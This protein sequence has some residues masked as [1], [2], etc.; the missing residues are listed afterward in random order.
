VTK[1]TFFVAKKSI[2]IQGKLLDL[3]NP[4]VMGIL[5]VTPDSFFEQSR[6]AHEESL[7]QKA[8]SMLE[9]GA[10]ILDIGG[11]ST[12]PGAAD[13][14]PEEELARV[15]PAIQLL[16]KN[17]PEV[18]ISIDTFRAEVA[19]Q[20]I[21]A[22]ANIIN[23]VSGGDIDV[24]MF[25]TVA[26][27][28]CPYILTHM[29]GTPQTMSAYTDYPKGLT[30]EMLDYFAEK[31][32][33]LR[34]IGV[35]DVIIDPGFGF[36]KT[37]EQNYELLRELESFKILEEPLLIGISRKSMITKYLGI[38]AKDALNGT[39]VINTLVLTKGAIILRVHDVKEAIESVKLFKMGTL[40]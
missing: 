17:I 38:D 3:S 19:K 9:A 39:T 20:A 31:L 33:L 23:D 35:K 8:Q 12:R 14:S 1:N 34:K 37:L 26:D 15:L 6:V 22:G 40:L 21:E 16:R 5:N 4:L 25:Q 29:R 28:R 24:R 32:T 30:V 10:A 11:Y 7:L 13:V 36:A 2:N 27:L 18:V